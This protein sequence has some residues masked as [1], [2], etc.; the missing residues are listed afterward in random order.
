MAELI[1]QYKPLYDHILIEPDPPSA[2]IGGIFI[3]EMAQEQPKLGT[4]AAVGHGRYNQA[5]G[6]L[7]PLVTKV[8]DRVRYEDYAGTKLHIGGREYLH[9][10]EMAVIA[11]IQTEVTDAVA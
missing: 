2:I 8:G 3:P 9:M 7:V 10:R 4:V 11:I 6:E 1:T 5:T